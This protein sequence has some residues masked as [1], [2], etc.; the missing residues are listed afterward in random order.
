[1]SRLLVLWQADRCWPLRAMPRTIPPRVWGDRDVGSLVCTSND[2]TIDDYHGDSTGSCIAGQTVNLD[3]TVNLQVGANQRYNVGVFIAGDG[4]R[5]D[6][7]AANGGS[8][9]CSVF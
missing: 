2:I 6:I 1:M 3:L 5:A 4:K 9:S 8:S 7:A